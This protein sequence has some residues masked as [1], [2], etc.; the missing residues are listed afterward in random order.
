MQPQSAFVYRLRC[1]ITRHV[2]YIGISDNPRTRLSVHKSQF[3]AAPD[4]QLWLTQ[5]EQDGLSPILE[6]VTDRLDRVDA[7][8]VE[9]RLVLLFSTFYP[10]QLYNSPVVIARIRTKAMA[11]EPAF[12]IKQVRRGG[13][14]YNER[15]ARSSR[16][17]AA[18]ASLA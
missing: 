8:A 5:L 10:G 18:K 4:M 13:L 3:W 14:D 16:R 6:V 2:R 7:R 9:K 1:P 12:A 11:D 17:S 15:R